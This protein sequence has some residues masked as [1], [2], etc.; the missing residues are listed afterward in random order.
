MAAAVITFAW[1]SSLFSAFE[2]VVSFFT[3]FIVGAASGNAPTE[4][5]TP[6]TPR[7][8]RALFYLGFAAGIGFL[9]LCYWS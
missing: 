3:G 2:V 6:D 1:P 5:F 4:S 8:I 9:L 7:L